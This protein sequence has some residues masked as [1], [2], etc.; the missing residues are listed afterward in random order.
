MKR[1]TEHPKL[2]FPKRQ[3]RTQLSGSQ[4]G[5][6]NASVTCYVAK[7]KLPTHSPEQQG[8]SCIVPHSTGHLFV[9]LGLSVSTVRTHTRVCAHTHTL[10]LS[11]S[12]EQV[13]FCRAQSPPLVQQRRVKNTG[14]G[15][16][17]AKLLAKTVTLEVIFLSLR[18]C[19]ASSA[20]SPLTPQHVP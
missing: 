10:A 20:V 8:E 3:Y 15:K 14:W 16:L 1:P 2:H 7:I 11:K 4:A 13:L 19:S 9:S 17:L 12:P 18:I 5:Q 6:Q